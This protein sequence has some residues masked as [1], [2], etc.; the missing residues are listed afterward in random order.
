VIELRG[1]EALAVFG[2]ARQAIRA[3]LELQREFMAETV[4]DPSLPLAVGVG[5][6]AGE[7]VAVEGG[8]RG[9]ALNLAARLC[10]LAGAGEIFASRE[11]THLARRVDG[12]RYVEHGA[13]RLKGLS[14]PVDVVRVRAELE[15]P[16]QDLRFRRALGLGVSQRAAGIESR[17]PYKG[18]RPFGEADAA[19]FFGREALTEVLV[20]R[21]AETR[22]LAVVGPSGSGKSSV[23]RAGL[24]PALR[25]GALPGSESWRIVEMVPG[26]Y[27]LEELEAALLRVAENPPASLLEQLESGDEGLL[28]AAK[29]VLPQ[30]G[31]E[32]VLVID[33]LEELFTLV[34][35]EGRRTRFLSLLRR[36]V[37]DP[38]SRLRIVTT[39]RA[40]FYD[41]PLLYSGFAELLRDYVAVVVPLTPEEFERAISRPAEQAGLS[42]EPGLLAEM[43]ADVTGEPGALPLLQYA[44]TEL[45]ERREGT[46]LTRRA[47]RAIGGAPAAL[48]GRA[49]ELFASLAEPAREATRQLFLRLVT[50]GEGTEDTRRRV[51]VA[52][53]RSI[54]VDQD[55]MREATDAFGLA[56][57][58]SFDR[59]P[60]TGSA[61]VE[62]AHEALLREWGR[63]RAWIDTARDSVRTHR[64]LAAAAAEWADSDRDASFLLRGG[65]LAQFES[66][67]DESGLALSELE[68]HFLRAS[69]DAREADRAAEAAR[70]AREAAV[71]RRSLRRM[72]ALLAVFAAAA[73]VAAGLTIYAFHEN[74]RSKHEARI[75]TGRALTADSVANLAVDP[76]LSILL[77][78]RAIET[79]ESTTKSVPREAVEALHRA[80]ES[81]RTTLTLTAPATK[82]VAFSPDGRVLA[83]AGAATDSQQGGEAILWNARTGRTLLTFPKQKQ[84][85]GP[86]LRF[87]R[88]GS[89]LY[90]II[91]GRGTVAWDTRTGK[92]VLLLPDTSPLN[93]IALSPDET[94]LATTGGDG[95]LKIWN[96]RTGK[97]LLTITAPSSLCGTAFN[98]SGTAIAA[99]LCFGGD[100]G[101]EVWDARNGKKLLTLGGPRYGWAF[102]VGYSPDGER[103]VSAGQDGK[104][105]VWDAHSGRLLATLVGHTGWIWAA[106][107][108]P[109][110][111][112]IGTS[113]SDGTARIWDARTGRELLV[114]AGHTKNVF[115]I[116]F[117]PDGTRVLTGSVDGTARVW[118]VRPQGARDAATLPAQSG[119]QG[120]QVS[121]YSPDGKL[122][123]VGGGGPTPAS[124]WNPTTGKKLRNLAHDGDVFAAAFSPGGTRIV[125]SGYGAPVVV[126]TASGRPVLKLR[127]SGTGFQPGAA[128]SPDGMLIALGLASAPSGA[129]L[130]DAHTGKLL[131]RFPDP[132]GASAVAFSPDGRLLAAGSFA[133]TVSIWDVASAQKRRTLP[134][135]VGDS[136]TDIA[137]SQDGKLATSSLNGTA[138]IWD[139]RSGRAL[140]TIQAQS[141]ALWGVSFSPN[142]KVLATAGDDTTARLWDVATGK[143][144]L[145]LTGASFALRHVTFSPDGTRLTTASGD[146]TVHIYVL[147]LG[148]LMNLARSRLTRGWVATECQRYLLTRTCPTTP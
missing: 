128:W 64:T 127:H 1:D 92:Q 28:R 2:S 109:D 76:E 69:I 146:G 73:L 50:L 136:I 72:R 25:R 100:G 11:L 116:T 49:E 126:D 135:S 30:G 36:P 124:L 133:G 18:L 24:I 132:A 114:L 77:A 117:S 95:R 63:L 4:A 51:S 27:P 112:R 143:E 129:G 3:A 142:G 16:A 41:R 7:V 57:L 19:D 68:R 6:D 130:W 80:L 99:A 42:L 118:D 102:N 34:E 90:T 45:Y 144:L 96:L 20:A 74:A 31:S 145:T 33:Q 101:A 37:A 48:A 40:D 88:D 94:R 81:S 55:A 131:R 147:P 120:A 89:R 47:Y 86:D 105:R 22:F 79:F 98:P 107:F 54:E 85:V 83:T 84:L 61:T 110:G 121:D 78:L 5:L 12:I 58:L 93:N 66:W 38:G 119:V 59:D 123:A 140:E 71:E 10:A 32:L 62:V 104:A 9:G 82:Y 138:T 26:A 106:R 97:R 103:I 134:G 15:D 44:L 17:N 52:E 43:L 148:A 108:S 39:L 53:L 46:V 137:F 113:S 60:R 115:D 139:T 29:R 13:I 67:S 8:Y 14:E 122:L 87:S 65:R 141:G 35:D 21:L 91:G 75:A 125:L 70:V 111:G 56:R 23:V